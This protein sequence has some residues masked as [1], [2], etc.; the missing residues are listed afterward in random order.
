M[1]KNTVKFLSTHW[2]K[3]LAGEIIYTKLWRKRI[4]IISGTRLGGLKCRDTNLQ[5]YGP[6]SY[7]NIGAKGGR[8]GRGEDYKGGFA[9]DEKGPDGL[10]GKQR[11][12]IAGSKG[13]KI[14]RRGPAKSK[15]ENKK[16]IFNRFFK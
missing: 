7:K 4:N 2:K 9:C 6:N 11:A 8:A 10:T 5:K 1:E 14:S 15:N 16:S 13:G 3:Q 12:S